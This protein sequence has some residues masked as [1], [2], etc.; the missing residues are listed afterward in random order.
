MIDENNLITNI[1]KG[2]TDTVLGSKYLSDKSNLKV[3]DVYNQDL[4]WLGELPPGVVINLVV[5]NVGGP[6]L[7]DGFNNDDNEYTLIEGLDFTATANLPIPD[8]KFKVPFKRTDTGRIQ[9]MMA[10]VEN[11]IATIKGQFKSS[12]IW[13]LNSGLLNMDLDRPKFKMS[14]LKFTVL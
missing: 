5:S 1:V 13:V 14:E 9:P 4:A 8:R 7:Q 12:G 10:T 6:A 11:G 2:T 3:G